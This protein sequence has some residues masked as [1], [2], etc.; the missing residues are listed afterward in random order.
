MKG[1]NKERWRELCEQAS[2]EQVPKR[3]S[4][5]VAEIDR[6][7]QEKLERLHNSTQIQNSTT[8]D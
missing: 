3:L 1:P 6:I 7:L 2:K 5:L 4:E 8:T